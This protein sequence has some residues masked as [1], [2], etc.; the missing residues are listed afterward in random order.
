M[1][2]ISFHAT[3]ICAVHHNG[4][5]AMAGDGQ[6]TMGEKVIM[7]GTARKVRRI[8]NDKV[9]VGFAGS[10]ADA[11][12][13]EERFEKKLN[14]YSGNLQ[15]AAVEL[16]Q[17]WRSDQTL[18]KLEALL[19]VMDK[20]EL[21]LVSGGGEVIAPDDEILA[22]GSGGNYA[23]AAAKAL[24]KHAPDMSAVEIAKAAIGIAGDIDIFTNHNIIA[25]EL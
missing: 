18:Q 17:E 22:I 23:L 14:E 12:N 13:L 19:I 10:V 3:T 20:H 4:H 16:A 11:F 24:K 6:V 9:A 15:R 1:S 21:L 8:Y 2:G 25:E 5:T 7:K